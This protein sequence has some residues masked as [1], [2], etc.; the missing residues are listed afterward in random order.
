MPQFRRNK[1]V[2]TKSSWDIGKSSENLDFCYIFLQPSKFAIIIIVYHHVYISF[3]SS[4]SS[5]MIKYYVRAINL[6]NH[7]RGHV[8]TLLVFF[9]FFFFRLD[10]SL[11]PAAS[12]LLFHPCLPGK[13]LLSPHL[14]TINSAAQQKDFET[15]IRVEW[16]RRRW[17]R[18]GRAGRASQGEEEEGILS[19]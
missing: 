12:F 7:C 13:K 6:R 5:Y 19:R 1:S 11:F 4:N 3:Y 15:K 18:S 2:I 16:E 8:L 9:F 10:H 14:E 17:F